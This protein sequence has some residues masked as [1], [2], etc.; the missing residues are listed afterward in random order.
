[1]GKILSENFSFK[2]F[3]FRK[4]LVSVE[5]PLIAIVSSTAAMLQTQNPELSVGIGLATTLI[6]NVVKYFVKEYKEE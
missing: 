4:W 6:Y 5:K 3:S 2:G 1:M